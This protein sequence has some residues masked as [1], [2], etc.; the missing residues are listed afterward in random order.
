MTEVSA[1]ALRVPSPNASSQTFAALDLGSNSFHL[2]VALDQGER[3]QVVDRHREMVRLAAGLGATRELSPETEGRALACLE[4]LG[5]RLRE[6]P[7]RNVRIVGTNT[8]RKAR[9]SRSFIRRAEKALGHRIEVISG[10]EEAR[11]I[12]LGVSHS[13]EDD[14]DSRLVVDIGGGSTEVILG[15][16]FQ[17]GLMESL[18]IG[19]VGLSDRYFPDGTITA[20]AMDAAER[21]ARLELEP[22]EQIFLARGWDTAIGASGTALSVRGVVEAETGSSEITRAGLRHVRERLLHAGHVERLDFAAVNAER[23]PVFPGGVAILSAIFA[24]LRIERMSVSDGALREGLLQ[25]LLGRVHDEDIRER[26]VRDLAQ[27]YHI[28]RDHAGRVARTALNLLEQV[29]PTW[30][31]DD[32]DLEALLRWGATL[33]EIGLDIAHN[34]YH[35]HGGYLLDHMD[36]A[37]FSRSEQHRV[38]LLVRAHRRKFPAEDFVDAEDIMRLCILLRLAVVLHRG[39]TDTPLP[40]FAITGRGDTVLVSL[41]KK[42]LL[43]HPLTEL[44]LQQEVEY[45]ANAPI[46]LRVS[47]P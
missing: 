41:P 47:A 10:R 2:I 16:R 31:M 32:P 38:S 42:W 6:L 21:A 9:N 7:A 15:R 23:A 11:L 30:R 25:D 29:G 17:P 33:H 20:Q 1:P 8:L 45:L 19:C 37:G 22:V 18:F 46:R 39:R 28:D 27:R 3:L 34:Q 26:T 35:K 12:Y 5:Q 40:S 14:R 44:D 24:S 13:L 36:L 4:R 43:A